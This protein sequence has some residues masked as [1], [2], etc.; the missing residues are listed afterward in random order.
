MPNTLLPAPTKALLIP[1]Q[2]TG[3]TCRKCKQTIYFRHTGIILKE[4]GFLVIGFK[5]CRCG[6]RKATKHQQKISAMCTDHREF[7]TDH[8]RLI[9]EA[10][11]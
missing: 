5:F 6:V 2:A 4:R 11:S 3:K 1:D 8:N 7:G 9:D 10:A